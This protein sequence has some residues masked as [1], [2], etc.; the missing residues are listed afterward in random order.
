[1]FTTLGRFVAIG[2]LILG[3]LNAIMGVSI[4]LIDDPEAKA[5]AIQAFLTKPTGKTIDQALLYIFAGIVLGVLT[6]ISRRLE[7]PQGK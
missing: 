1:M 3:I 7:K 5:S 4:A 6:D 2:L